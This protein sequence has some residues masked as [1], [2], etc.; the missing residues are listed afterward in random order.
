VL[1]TPKGTNFYTE[2]WGL[3]PFARGNVHIASTDPLHLLRSA[4]HISS[5]LRITVDYLYKLAK[6]MSHG[7][8]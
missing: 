8:A 3:L 4:L 1:V 7:A 5:R 2:Y 6:S